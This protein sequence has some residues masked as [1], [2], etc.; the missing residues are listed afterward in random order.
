MCI[1]DGFL[2]IAI[3]PLGSSGELPAEAFNLLLF[4]AN[5]LADPFLHFTGDVFYNTFDLIF[6]SLSF[7]FIQDDRHSPPKDRI[8]NVILAKVCAV[9]NPN[10][11][12][13]TLPAGIACILRIAGFVTKM[14]FSSLLRQHF[15]MYAS[16]Q[17]VFWPFTIIEP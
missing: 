16:I 6:G 12:R 17:N 7:F 2:C 4:A 1:I 8:L 9:T 3:D 11:I 14:T 10:I 5:Q 15:L 13:S